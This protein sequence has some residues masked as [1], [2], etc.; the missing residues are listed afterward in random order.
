MSDLAQRIDELSPAR[1]DL[2]LRR[3]RERRGESAAAE[4]D[5]PRLVP[6]P[7]RRHEPFP[8]NGVQQA[9]WA[10]RSGLFDLGT[11]GANGY[12]ELHFEG[13]SPASLLAGL[14]AAWRKLVARHDM[15]RMV[16][17]PGGR[18]QVLE[19][20]P[21][22]VLGTVDLRR[23]DEP[24]AAA[25]LG[26][27]RRALRTAMA[28]VE[29]WP[30]FE[31]RAFVLDGDQVRL[32]TRFELLAIDGV[33]RILLFSELFDLLRQP[34]LEP[35]EIG[36]TYRD[37]VLTWESF[38]ASA[39]FRRDR[40]FWLRLHQPALPPPELP[41]AREVGPTTPSHYVDHVELALAPEG[42]SSLK[43]RLT[44]LRLTP[45][46]LVTATFAEVLAAWTR[47]PG[48][49]LAVSGVFK[50]PLHP[51]LERV[52]GNFNSLTLL[53]IAG[54]EGDFTSRMRRLH[55]LVS[56]CLD[57]ASFS[58]F[59]LVRE[60][61]RGG[62]SSRT[63]V[64]VLFDS[65]LELQH[66]RYGYLA[67]ELGPDARAR[68]VEASGL[69]V[70]Q[71]QLVV[72]I[73]E[74]GGA[75][76]HRWR[77]VEGIF[78]P[79]LVEQ[80]AAAHRRRLASLAA[81]PAAWE[82][83]WPDVLRSLVAGVER[84]GSAEPAASTAPPTSTAPVTSTASA[85]STASEATTAS[86]ANTA[87]VAEEAAEDMATAPTL[88]EL[89]ARQTAA[90]PGALALTAPGGH[91]LTYGELDA[92]ASGMAAALARAGVGRGSV[93][94]IASDEGW[95]L[96]AAILAV[97]RAGAACLAAD[98]GADDLRRSCLLDRCDAL[99]MVTHSEEEAAGWPARLKRIRLAP[100]PEARNPRPEP[101]AGD[102]A[103][104]PALD[105]VAYVLPAPHAAGAAGAAVFTHRALAAAVSGIQRLCGI[106]PLDR[107]L[108]L[109]P[110][111][112]EQGLG[113]LLGALAA[114]AA[115]VL[116]L[117]E[118]RRQAAALAAVVARQ[119][120]SVA[121]L[122][123]APCERLVAE[124]ES[125]RP[126]G[127]LAGLR[128][129]LLHG[130]A[131]PAGLPERLARL[132]PAARSWLLAGAFGASLAAVC[133][134][135]GDVGPEGLAG[136]IPLPGQTVKVLGPALAPRPP[137]VVGEVFLGG[138][139]L[140]REWWGEDAAAEERCRLDPVTG[141]RLLGT[142]LLGRRLPGGRLDWLGGREEEASMLGYRVALRRIAAC[143]ERH[144]AV[145]TA[146]VRPWRNAAGRL[147]PW[148]YVVAAGPR[149]ATAAELL[150]HV[151]RALPYYMVP[152]GLSFL[153][154]W[155]LGG[156]GA[157]DERAL[158]SPPPLAAADRREPVPGP[159]AKDPVSGPAPA[160]AE[161]REAVPGPPAND[162]AHS[163]AARELAPDAP[164]LT[165]DL[166][167]D[168]PELAGELARLWEGMLGCERVESSDD[169]FALGGDSLSLT[170]MMAWVRERHGDGL[171]LWE[172]FYE[173][174]LDNLVRLIRAGAGK[175]L[176]V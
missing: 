91:T 36:C 37:Y 153:D 12:F 105:D 87:S 133:R 175:G 68:Y 2:L 69:Y 11:V 38:R 32:Q 44:E 56:A 165:G 138:P 121:S 136:G 24:A 160:A 116:P 97:L 140:A 40:E 33:M 14:G 169:F 88:V 112:G 114:G 86:M 34:D 126:D 141:E 80:M 26:A 131:V 66:R 103:A 118:A 57:H 159:P 51:R 148:A 171:P 78:P 125:G 67:G 150:Q 27:S 54:M 70:S 157:V 50:P 39:S 19:R 132:A 43:R 16:A 3:L 104:G 110:L 30:Q 142:G 90:R 106:G 143:L 158:P 154:D 75:L 7:E 9:Y 172:F 46:A 73:A 5:L 85:A 13:F 64:P 99:A 129:L 29:R 162:P 92:A 71:F 170:R 156:D 41:L 82:T 164:R 83:P 47:E 122:S 127:G 152:A 89:F 17:L 74:V 163:P 18:Q 63:P 123:P 137:W 22:Y 53:P 76:Q 45:T 58:G 59:E 10:G 135:L 48:F 25:A 111:R 149:G 113:D 93:V 72:F 81:D 65:L 139:T 98:P 23:L 120:P 1:R 55:E 145:R 174:T 144:P 77:Y 95:E 84:E 128:C 117:P 15:L 8:L 96:A 62:G 101:A 108:G 61:G 119:R 79:G 161:R 155:P 28:P 168:A 31:L 176:R 60:L 134:P 173:P 130:D 20:V 151:A 102:G 166:A 6:D 107:L 124:A 21:D 35:P 49:T 100:R 115:L 109:A 94:A 167:P 147:R 42:W 4:P 146:F 52:V